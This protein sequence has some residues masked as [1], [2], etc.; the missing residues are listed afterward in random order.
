MEKRF[1]EFNN[2][3]KNNFDMNNKKIKLKYDHTLR[4]VE[5]AKQIAQDENLSKSDVDLAIV[6]ALL[7][8]NAK[9]KQI[10]KYNTFLDKK[11]FDHGDEGYNILISN[12]FINKFSTNEID[13]QIILKTVRNHNKFKLE[14][15]LTKKQLYFCKLV[16]DADKIDIIKTCVKEIND[17]SNTINPNILKEIKN[18][19]LCSNKY[20]NN[21]CEEII[22]YLGFIYDL[23]FT[24]SFE[25]IRNSNIINDR[26]N[27]L[28]Q[29][30]KNIDFEN[31]KIKLYNYIDSK[32][33]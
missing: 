24:K 13:K 20:A 19:K 28:S 27:L 15:D 31:I 5:Y 21:C 9:F 32:L 8:N 26:I 1:D 12:N 33:N 4:V 3:V 14:N 11:S 7:H 2:Y 30:V 17:F 29:T 18:E 6:C 10:T 22:R 16:R 25:I 23:N